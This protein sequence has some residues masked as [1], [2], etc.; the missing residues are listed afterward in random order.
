MVRSG[1]R[2]VG[3]APGPRRQLAGRVEPADVTDLVQD[4][5]GGQFSDAGGVMSTLTQGSALASART[6]TSS[7][8]IGPCI[9]SI[10]ARQS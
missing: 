2:V 8:S 10:K 6:S 1:P 9:A 3:G 7:R 4:D 5:Q